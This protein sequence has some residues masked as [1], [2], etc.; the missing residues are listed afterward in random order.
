MLKSIHP[1]FNFDPFF[2]P[3]PQNLRENIENNQGKVLISK[4]N[5][6]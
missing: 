5:E 4:Y 2:S 1:E 3:S 6:V